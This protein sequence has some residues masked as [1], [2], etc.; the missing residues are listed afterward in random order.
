MKRRDFLKLAGV[1]SIATALGSGAYCISGWWNQTTAESRHTLS[2]DEVTIVESILDAMFPGDSSAYQHANRLPNGL[3]TDALDHFDHYLGQLDAR[4]AKLMR[5][6][7]HAIDDIAF[8]RGLK[9]QRFRHRD[10]PERIRIL[11]AWDESNLG[12]RRSA[13]R[14]MKMALAGGY[15]RSPQVKRAAGI[16]FAC[17]HP[18]TSRTHT[19]MRRNSP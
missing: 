3:E 19:A 1:G 4:S 13:F 9:F 10:R 11:K 5:L 14:A 18:D 2:T 15:M 17:R 12:I 6:L 8:F 16:D 7:L